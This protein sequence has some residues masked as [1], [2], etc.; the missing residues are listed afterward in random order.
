M[1]LPQ[2]EKGGIR[3]KV[4]NAALYFYSTGNKNQRQEN[5]KKKWGRFRGEEREPGGAGPVDFV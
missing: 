2:N 5:S 1:P 3:G 4:A